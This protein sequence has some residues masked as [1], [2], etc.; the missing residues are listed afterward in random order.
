M[1]DLR[2]ASLLGLLALLALGGAAPTALQGQET[3]TFSQARQMAGEEALTATVR[4]GAGN[5]RVRAAEPGSFLRVWLRMP[6]ISIPG[7]L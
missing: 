5:L 2:S 4:Y 6:V 7:I 1:R 3:A